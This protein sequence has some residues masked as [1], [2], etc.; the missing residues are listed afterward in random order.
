LSGTTPD[1]EYKN[2]KLGERKEKVTGRER[3]RERERRR[4][5]EN[6]GRKD[7]EKQ[8]GRECERKTVRQFY[9]KVLLIVIMRKKFYL[10]LT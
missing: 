10:N 3:E 5:N 8:S 6:R 7:K 9:C 1:K 2:I 4:G